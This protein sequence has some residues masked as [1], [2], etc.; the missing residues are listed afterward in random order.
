MSLLLNGLHVSFQ[1]DLTSSRSFVSASV[2]VNLNL[3]SNWQNSYLA[4]I[5]VPALPSHGLPSFFTSSVEVIL[6]HNLDCNLVLG[7][8]WVG[9]CCTAMS[10]GL[11]DFPTTSPECCQNHQE[12][13]GFS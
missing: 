8:N 1:Y 12:N 6:Q 10:D 7:M 5:S 9:L 3:E 13:Q 2:A 4:I 11:V